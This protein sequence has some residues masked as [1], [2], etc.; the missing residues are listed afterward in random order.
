[1]VVR[2][3]R[4]QTLR[5]YPLIRRCSKP[6]SVA[7]GN[8][9]RY[10]PVHIHSYQH[11]RGKRASAA[12]RSAAVVTLAALHT[13]PREVPNTTAGVAGLASAAET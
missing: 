10:G 13:V 2:K 5:T 1:M 7:V 11:S 8:P 9:W 4:Q 12:Y 3:R 6:F